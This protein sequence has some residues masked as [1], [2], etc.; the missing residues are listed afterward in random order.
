MCLDLEDDHT[1]VKR[2]EHDHTP[3]K[4]FEHDCA[5]VKRFEHQ[6][7]K[8]GESPTCNATRFDW[9]SSAASDSSTPQRQHGY[10]RRCRAAR[11]LYQA[12]TLA[13]K[14]QRHRN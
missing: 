3:V 14:H 12:R 1:S 10:A 8:P 2:F 7:D 6:P 9:D 4:R 13:P 5:S 11:H